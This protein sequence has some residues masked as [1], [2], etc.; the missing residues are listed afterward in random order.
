MTLLRFIYSQ[1][2]QKPNSV[3]GYERSKINLASIK[4]L[5]HNEMNALMTSRKSL[6]LELAQYQSNSKINK[7][8]ME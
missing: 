3:K 6:Q 4:R 2:F 1:R 5:D 8:H 7:E